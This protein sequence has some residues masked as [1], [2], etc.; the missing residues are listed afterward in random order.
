MALEFTTSYLTDAIT[1][2]RY[3]KEMG[4]RA[5]AQA[6]DASLVAT[7]DSESNSIA[8]IVKHLSGNMV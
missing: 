2:F 8:T 4:D 6:P 3:Y 5:I 1:L 7:L